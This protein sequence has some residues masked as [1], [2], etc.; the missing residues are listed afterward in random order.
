MN[1]PLTLSATPN[2]LAGASLCHAAGSSRAAGSTL[3]PIE[4]G[5]EPGFYQVMASA[6]WPGWDDEKLRP[7]IARIPPGSWFM[8]V[9]NATNTIAATAMGLHDH[10][11]DH[12]S[13]GELT[14]RRLPIRPITAKGWVTWRSVRRDRT[15]D[16]RR[17]SKYPSLHQH[18]RL[19]ALKLYLKLGYVP[20]LTR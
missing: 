9:H 1:E 7:G 6:G 17:V 10:S 8:I 15:P 14:C 13:G 20:F 4:P 19:A 18:W 3:R 11:A 2:G 16:R 12:P 5:D